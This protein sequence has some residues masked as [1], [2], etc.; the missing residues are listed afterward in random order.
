MCTSLCGSVCART[1]GGGREGEEEGEGE[2]VM[3]RKGRETSYKMKLFSRIERF[4][5]NPSEISQK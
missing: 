4:P 3:E 5:S 2:G 1:P